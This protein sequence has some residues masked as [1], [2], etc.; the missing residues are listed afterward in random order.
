MVEDAL[1]AT[2]SPRVL[3]AFEVWVDSDVRYGGEEE[4]VRFCL[5]LDR[6][7]RT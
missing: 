7:V 3:Q 1:E 2:E 5:T 6:S 4:D